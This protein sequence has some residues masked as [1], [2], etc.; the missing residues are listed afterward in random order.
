ME[1]GTNAMISILNDEL[2]KVEGLD[3]KRRKLGM[4]ELLVSS[5]KQR[6]VFGRT[7]TGR[8]AVLRLCIAFLEDIYHPKRMEERMELFDAGCFDADRIDAYFAG[9]ETDAPVF[10]LDDKNRPFMQSAYDASM[11]EK[12]EKPVAAIFID[13]PSGNGHIHLD[14]RQPEEIDASASDALEGMLETYMYC[15]AGTQGPSQINNTNPVYCTIKGR[16]LFETLVLNMV[17]SDELANNIPFGDGMVPWRRHVVVK[18]K[19]MVPTVSFLEALTWQPRR[20]TLIFDDDQKVR[21]VYL[22]AG[23]NFIGDG[24]WRDPWVPYRKKKDGTDATIKPVQGRQIWR[25]MGDILLARKNGSVEPV[26]IANVQE[27]WQDIPNGIVPV[28]ALGLITNQASYIGL[29]HE[30]LRI[31]EALLQDGTKAGWFGKWIAITEEIYD[32][33]AR[34]ISGIYTPETAKYVGESFLSQMREAIFGESLRQL[35]EA[36]DADG[37]AAA[38]ICFGDALWA[39]LRSSLNRILEKSGTSVQNIKGRTPQRQQSWA[40]VPSD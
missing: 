4:R 6:D 35:I 25:D 33:A 1:G 16:N 29:A 20:L 8:L 27:I 36:D 39:S 12:A 13:L 5:H 9:C 7:P 28:E 34:I 17:A 24:R 3:G 15:T 18:P 2:F 31:P 23:R 37:M 38:D 10:L 32:S 30:M 22:Q 19:E 40:F 21:R 11:D 26:P 14:H